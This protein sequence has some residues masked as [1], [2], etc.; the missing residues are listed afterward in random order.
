MDQDYD[1]S[2]VTLLQLSRQLAWSWGE[3]EKVLQRKWGY[4]ENPPLS[5]TASHAG[6]IL[7]ITDFLKCPYDLSAVGSICLIGE[8]LLILPVQTAFTEAPVLAYRVYNTC[9]C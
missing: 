3:D 6:P 2:M 5:W 7:H 8:L 1:T 9:Y 4:G